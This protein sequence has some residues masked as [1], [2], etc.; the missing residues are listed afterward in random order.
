MS[1]PI[2]TLTTDFGTA[3]GAIRRSTPVRVQRG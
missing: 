3:D 1:G 2:T